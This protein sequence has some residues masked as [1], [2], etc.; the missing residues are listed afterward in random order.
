[1]K[2]LPEKE[3]IPGKENFPVLFGQEGKPLLLWREAAEA[4]SQKES[5]S[6]VGM[7]KPGTRSF[8]PLTSYAPR[9]T[10]SEFARR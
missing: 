4:V 8:P 6:G 3:A 2:V 9:T 7:Q 1:M 5:P 10:P